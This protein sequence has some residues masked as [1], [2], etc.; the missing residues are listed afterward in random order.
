MLRKI[1]VKSIIAS[2]PDQ[3]KNCDSIILPG[4]GSFDKGMELLEQKGFVESIL[5]HTNTERKKI[6]GICLGMQLLFDSSEEGKKTGLGLIDGIVTKF[7]PSMGLLIPNMGWRS[8]EFMKDKIEFEDQF[9][10]FYF[11]HS[12]YANCQ[13]NEDVWMLAEYGQK[14]VAAVKKENVYGVQFHPEKSHVY[15][16]ILLKAFLES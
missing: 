15:G 7:N 11:V 12:Y 2:N 3:L 1:G 8:I 5:Y 9:S 16:K 14:F 4:V 13:S 6:L 10:R